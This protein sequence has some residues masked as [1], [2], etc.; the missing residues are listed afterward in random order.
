MHCMMRPLRAI[1]TAQLE[2][3]IR[4]G[5]P[6]PLAAEDLMLFPEAFQ[7]LPAPAG[8]EL[9]E[10]DRLLKGSGLLRLSRGGLNL[11]AVERQP[12]FC[13]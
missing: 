8:P 7:N 3:C 9:F 12:R 2:A 5:R 6:F 11:W 1:G 4:C 13:S 10:V